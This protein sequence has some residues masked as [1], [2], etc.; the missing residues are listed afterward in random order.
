MS[1]KD[2]GIGIKKGAAETI[3]EEF[4]RAEHVRK[5]IKGSGIGLCIAKSAVEPHG[6]KIWAESEGEEKGSVFYIRLPSG[7]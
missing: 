2:S 7:H 6:G 1:V 3:F 4:V 5:E